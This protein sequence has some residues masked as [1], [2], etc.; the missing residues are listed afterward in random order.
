MSDDD[1]VH[2]QDVATRWNDNDTDGHLNNVVHHD[3]TDRK[4]EETVPIEGERRAALETL[5]VA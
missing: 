1:Y 4:S 2:W 5:Q 3:L